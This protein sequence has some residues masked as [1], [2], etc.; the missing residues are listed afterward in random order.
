ME[1]WLW[2]FLMAEHG[3]TMLRLN[4]LRNPHLTHFLLTMVLLLSRQQVSYLMVL[5]SH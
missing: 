4:T 3:L 1:A 2:S 5:L